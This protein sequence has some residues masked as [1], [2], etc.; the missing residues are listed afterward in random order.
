M[1]FTI[2]L[3]L[4]SCAEGLDRERFENEWWGF[5]KYP[6]CFNAHESGSLLVYED[7]IRSEGAWIF[8]E[9]NSYIV[10]DDMFDVKEEGSDCWDIYLHSKAM[11]DTACE[12]TLRDE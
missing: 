1:F 2:F 11:S 5:Q 7:K 3:A 4:L 10:N 6:L 9:P 12:C 8:E